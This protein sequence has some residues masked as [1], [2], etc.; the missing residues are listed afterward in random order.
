[1]L[2]PE[3]QGEVGCQD[4]SDGS[5]ARS[6]ND[7][8]VRQEVS[9]AMSLEESSSRPWATL[10]WC[11][12]LA[13]ETLQQVRMTEQRTRTDFYRRETTSAIILDNDSSPET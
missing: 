12:A 2:F 13:R 6:S 11:R 3:H 5:D 9:L 8:L 4:G 10:P 7:R 1:V